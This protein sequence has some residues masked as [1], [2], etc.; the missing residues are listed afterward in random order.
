MAE[1]SLRQIEDRLNAEFAGEGRRLIFWYDDRGDF[2]EDVGALELACAKVYRLE[3]DN[4][5]YTKYF[6]ERVDRET[7]YLVYAPFP[8]P[9]AEDNHLED[10]LLYSKRFCADRAALLCADLGI[11]EEHRWLIEKHSRLF[12]NK[13]FVQR[14]Y[15]LEID[16]FD[17]E[18]ILTGLLC[19][20]CQTRSCSFDEVVC[21]LLMEDLE[22]NPCL[23]KL[24]A[25]GLADTFWEFCGQQFGYTEEAPSLE[26]FVTALF[27]TCAD[28]YMRG[29]VH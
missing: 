8:K 27:V 18:T 11:G 3:P 24:Y 16:R 15:N 17:T 28:R 12:N 9:D 7:S 19:A 1:L 2:S 22:R 20:A 26:R 25:Q 14:F 10:T 6:L 5:F 29:L 4:Q 13:K 23:E 21:A